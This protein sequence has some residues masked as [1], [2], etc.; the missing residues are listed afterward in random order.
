MKKFLIGTSALVGAALLAAAAQAED[1][2]VMVGGVIDFQAGH[3]SEDNDAGRRNYGFRNDTEVSF[4][5]NGKADNGLGYGAVV[6]LEADVSSDADSEGVNA[7]RTYTF[8]DGSFG[9]IELGSNTGASEALAVEADNLARATGGIDG[10]WVYFATPTGA[11]FITTPALPAEH[12]STASFNDESTFNAT[13]ITYYSPRFSGFQVGLGL[14]PDLEDRGQS[15][16]RLDSGTGFGDVVEAGLN[17]QGQFNNV[18]LAAAWTGQMGDADTSAVED[19]RAWNAGLTA[20]FSGFSLGGSY[21]DWSD[22]GNVS[23]SDS[24][25]YTL[26]AAYDFGPFGASVTWLDSNVEVAGSENDFDNLVFGADY[27]LA[28]GLTPYAELSFFDADAAGA[29]L[30]NDGTVLLLGTELSF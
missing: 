11:S 21:G 1:P 19:L 18:G 29:A 9:R 4:S 13:K 2:K 12:G 23:D 6:S 3:I 25:Y 20:T 10:A 7:S 26:G 22:S 5:V 14:T 24:D 30:D 15:L 16:T 27:A 28:P 17:Y 8:L